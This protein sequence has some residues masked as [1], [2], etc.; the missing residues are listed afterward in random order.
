MENWSW[1]RMRKSK[2]QFLAQQKSSEFLRF[3]IKKSIKKSIEFN[4]QLEE[5]TVVSRRE[6]C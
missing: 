5:R 1:K 2:I 4:V 6:Q 3:F